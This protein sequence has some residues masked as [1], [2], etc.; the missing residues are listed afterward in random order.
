[1]ALRK[2]CSL[3]GRRGTKRPR[4]GRHRRSGACRWKLG[5]L[6]LLGALALLLLPS[7]G[8]PP[9]AAAARTYTFAVVPQFE[10]RKLFAT[11][12]PIIDELQ[13]R[14]GVSF[15]LE[16]TLTVPQL[17][18][19]LA[20]GDFDFVYANP[21]Q[22]FREGERQGYLPLVRDRTPLRGIVVVRKDSPI[23][24]VS[25]LDGRSIAVP[26]LN[27]FGACLLVRA[28]LLRL[29]RVAI[30]PVAVQTHTSV[31]LH[32]INGLTVAGGGVEK[33]LRE[34][35]EA[36]QDSLRVLY[37]TRGFPS[38]PVASH[39]RVPKEVREKVRRAFLAMG[40]TAEGRE[41]LSK[42]PMQQVVPTSLQDYLPLRDLQLE[43]F[44]VD[45]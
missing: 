4:V 45:G 23:R 20:N 39:P 27:S 11:W 26:S 16:T 13:R 35:D 15:E 34:Q 21:Y 18:R 8:A 24:S 32:V 1:M 29:H 40:A 44:W 7:L 10:Q 22:V 36:V 6:A 30:N 2:I 17:E 5:K 33:T 38:H 28:D 42:V 12:K 41:L 31:Y 43:S 19:K 37:T 25:E 14:T 3:L 9:R